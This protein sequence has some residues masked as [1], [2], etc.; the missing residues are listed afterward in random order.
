MLKK[1]PNYR[2]L[3]L[4]ANARSLMA[5]YTYWL[6]P[7]HLLMVQVSNYTERYRRFYFRDIQS[8]L[9]Q[10]SAIRLI[11]NIVLTVLSLIFLFYLVPL[12]F[13]STRAREDMGVAGMVVFGFLFGLCVI[14]FL[15]NNLRGQTFTV[16]IGTAVQTQKLGHVL[17][18]KAVDR[19]MAEISPLILATQ[20][21]QSSAPGSADQTSVPLTPEDLPPDAPSLPA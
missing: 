6:A 4:S 11:Y 7:D 14:G 21:A 12:L 10:R 8:I 13:T 16:H 2:R 3:K 9:V 15:A 1:D 18:Q 19:L 5:S 17:R 20:A